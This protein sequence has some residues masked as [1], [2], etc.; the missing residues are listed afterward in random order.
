[1]LIVNVKVDPSVPSVTFQNI[2]TSPFWPV[3]RGAL[4]KP[5]G[6][7]KTPVAALLTTHS[8]IRVPDGVA[9]PVHAGLFTD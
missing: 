5:A 6:P 2:W 4:L 7:V 8:R 9:E 3:A 1:M